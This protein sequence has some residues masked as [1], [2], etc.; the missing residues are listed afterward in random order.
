MILICHDH[1]VAITQR[2]DILILLAMLQPKDLLDVLHLLVLT[3]LTGSSITHVE[4]LTPTQNRYAW[5]LVM[6]QSD[7]AGVATHDCTHHARFTHMCILAGAAL[8]PSH[9]EV[10]AT[11]A[12]RPKMLTRFP[13]CSLPEW[14]HTKVVVAHHTEP[15]DGQCLG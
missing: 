3:D 4:Q 8:Q 6:L 7:A 13:P 9:Q 1:K 14:E 10:A 11:R 12:S 2:L 5:I 15:A